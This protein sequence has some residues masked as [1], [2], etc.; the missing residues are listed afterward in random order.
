M[1]TCLE[2]RRVLFRSPGPPGADHPA[3][4]LHGSRCPRADRDR[5]GGPQSAGPAVGRVLMG[6]PRP[7]IS[8]AR[9]WDLGSARPPERRA[10]GVIF[11]AQLVLRPLI[12]LLAGRQW[13]EIGRAHV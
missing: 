1:A 5:A 12:R 10:G 4:P 6:R 11:V 2:F 9:S 8:F 7:T 13:I 3:S